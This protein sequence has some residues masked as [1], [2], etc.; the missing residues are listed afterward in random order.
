MSES[1]SLAISTFEAPLPRKLEHVYTLL[2]DM[3]KGWLARKGMWTDLFTSRF[4]LHFPPPIDE[5]DDNRDRPM[6]E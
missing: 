1:R 6:Y 2:K 3:I 5:G 4:Q